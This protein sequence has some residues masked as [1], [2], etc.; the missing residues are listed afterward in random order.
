MPG[1]LDRLLEPQ[2]K[3]VTQ[4]VDVVVP[5][6]TPTQPT[7]D[8]KPVEIVAVPEPDFT[9][10]LAGTPFETPMTLAKKYFEAASSSGEVTEEM[11]TKLTA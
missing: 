11:K 7:E 4:P 2:S 3:T 9:K 10:S 1:I 8:L 6:N 5:I